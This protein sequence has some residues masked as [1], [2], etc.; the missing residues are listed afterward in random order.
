MRKNKDRNDGKLK[1]IGFGV[2]LVSVLAA[3]ALNILLLNRTTEIT[4]QQ[5]EIALQ[6]EAA[7]KARI[8]S[9][10]KK[11]EKKPEPKP[12]IQANYTTK[13]DFKRLE[14]DY[15]RQINALKREIR[16]IRA[17]L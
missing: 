12:A 11:A 9:E 17:L 5:Q 4:A 6:I 10:K 14:R 8:E 16:N 3:V 13:K 15:K 2:I 1:I 7:E